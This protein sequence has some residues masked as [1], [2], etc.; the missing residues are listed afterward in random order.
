MH[1]VPLT[2]ITIV[3]EAVLAEPL[4]RAL[5]ALGVSGHTLSEA[6]GQGSRGRRTGEIPGDNVRIETIVDAA[7]A[8][9]IFALLAET[10]FPNYAVVAWSTAI[11]VVRG[12]KYV[13]PPRG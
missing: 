11:Q 4:I 13:P 6:R 3:G 7:L 9:R 12:E 10:Y 8:D 5:H 2:L 1:T